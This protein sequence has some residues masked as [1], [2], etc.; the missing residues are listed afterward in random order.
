M[1]KTDKFLNRETKYNFAKNLEITI[2]WYM[3][4]ANWWDE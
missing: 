1:T 3:N 4:N 2:D